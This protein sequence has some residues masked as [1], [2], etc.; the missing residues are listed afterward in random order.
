MN[1]PVVAGYTAGEMIYNVMSLSQTG[2]KAVSDYIGLQLKAKEQ[3][4]RK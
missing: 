4:K 3:D 2:R 1:K